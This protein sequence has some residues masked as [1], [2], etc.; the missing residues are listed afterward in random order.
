MKKELFNLI[1]QYCQD[2]E[3]ITPGSK[4]VIGLSGGPDSVFLLHFFH[5]IK[6][7][8]NLSLIAAHLNHEWRA[9]AGKDEQFCSALAQS[10][11]ITFASQKISELGLALKF[12]GSKEEI[13][14]KARRHFLERVKSEY[15]AHVIALGHHAQD[16]QET[17]FI[18]LMR[19]SSLSGLTAMK[20]RDG[21]YIRPLLK[22]NKKDIISYLKEHNIEYLIDP[23]NE[24]DEYLRNRIRKK[25]VPALAEVDSRFDQNFQNTLDRLQETES[26]LIQLTTGTLSKTSKTENHIL[27]IDI[28]QLLSLHSELRY[29]V[30]MQWL[31]NQKVK[32]PASQAF[33]D[34]LMRFVQSSEKK[35]HLMNDNWKLVKKENLAWIVK[36]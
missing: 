24:S 33:L 25:V 12:N 16:Q 36:N 3:L 4:I 1:T 32:F 22:T 10:L 6:N 14:R 18:R 17:F 2:H 13:G 30:I 34:E 8:Y 11:G 28:S 5:A 21:N 23:S 29:R 15:D 19:G 31:I 35:E 9:E 26:F 27:K 7:H 20:P